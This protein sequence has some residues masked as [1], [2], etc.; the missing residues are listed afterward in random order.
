MNSRPD[1]NDAT[2]PGPLPAH[3]AG[4]EGINIFVLLPIALILVFASLA[5]GG[6]RIKAHGKLDSRTLILAVKSDPISLNPVLASDGVSMYVNSFIFNT[7]VRYDEKMEIVPDLARSWEVLDGGRRVVFHLRK[8]VKWHDGTEMTAGDCAFTMEKTLDPATNTFNGSLFKVDG[9]NIIFRAVDPYTLEARLPAPFAPFFNNLTL[10]GIV[11]RHLLQREDINWAAF[12][13]SPVGTGPFRL[14]SWK[15]SDEL[16]LHAN[17]GYFNGK[18][19]LDRVKFKIIPSGEGSRIALLSGQV[20]VAG[21]SSEDLF[22]MKG[23]V[24]PHVRLCRWED[25]TYYYLSFDLTNGKFRD[26][27]VRKAIS[28]AIDVDTLARSILHGSG[29]PIH[30][31]IP[32][33]SWAYEP[34]V[35]R[36]PFSRETAA[37]LL[38]EAGWKTGRTGIRV[39]DGVP[40]SFRLTVRSGSPAGEGAAIFIQSYLRDVGIDVRIQPLDF[41]ALIRSLYPGKYEAVIF[42]W[43]EPFDP[44]I[45]TEWHSSQMGDE[46]MN[47]MSYANEDVDGLLSRARST[48]DRDERK[49]LYSH[50]QK[51]IAADAPYVFLWNQETV[52]GVNSRVK[53]LSPPS[54]A[55]LITHPERVWLEEK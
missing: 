47:F 49:M 2:R 13:R 14:S 20:D 4:R 8:G 31:P 44:D 7:L 36:L 18:P 19:L 26:G 46:G 10:V 12:N 1:K 37:R 22:I 45:F 5:Y 50:A 11:P 3:R 43:V 34:D 24:P 55:G 27:R 51:K 39:K 21:L 40:L 41:G 33:A 17:E 42:D 6:S 15:V 29:K 38:D 23:K 48:M 54:P 30:G 28:H 53:G 32:I 25:F 9:K 35:P 16:I 52:M